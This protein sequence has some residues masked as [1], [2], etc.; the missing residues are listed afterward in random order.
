MSWEPE[1]DELRRREAL[2]RKMGGPEKL[3]R[4]HNQGKLDVRQTTANLPDETGR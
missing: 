1:I 3:A 4:H 2:A